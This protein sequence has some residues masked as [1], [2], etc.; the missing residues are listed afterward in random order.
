MINTLILHNKEERT[1]VSINLIKKAKYYHLI[2]RPIAKIDLGKVFD[3]L[4]QVETV[5]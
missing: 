4:K 5:L 1:K 2:E 3:K